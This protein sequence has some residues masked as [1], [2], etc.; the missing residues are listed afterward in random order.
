MC[1]FFRLIDYID[2]TFSSWMTVT[3]V[4]LSLAEDAHAQQVENAAFNVYP[5]SRTH[6]ELNGKLSV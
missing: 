3:D 4:I 2:G 5:G 1:N 6:N